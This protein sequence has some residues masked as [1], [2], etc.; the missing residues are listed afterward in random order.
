MNPE[1]LKKLIPYL[2]A[3]PVF[4]LATLSLFY[5][6]LLENK[7]LRQTDIVQFE[8]MKHFSNIY[9]EEN[10]ETA[11]WNIGMFS[12]FPEF[13]MAGVPDGGFQFLE[14]LTAGF[15][16]SE[17][18]AHIFFRCAFCCWVMLLCFRL[19]PYLSIMG[20]LAFAFNTYGIVTLEAGHFTKMWAI[21]YA[22]LVV[23][24]MKLLFD[25]KYLL[26]MAVFLGGLIMELRANHFQITY[27]LIIVCLA[28]GISELVYAIRQNDLKDFAKIAVLLL[29]GAGIGA[30]TQTARLWMTLDYSQYSTRGERELPAAE[31]ERSSDN[32]LDK[33]YAFS[34]SQG[35][36]ETL[37][38]LVP[39]LYGGSSNEVPDK[40]SEF[41]AAFEKLAG[42]QQARNITRKKQGMLPLYHGDQPFTSG[43]VYAGA[44]LVFL[45][46]LGMILLPN[47]H[48]IWM[49]VAVLVTMAV[50]WGQNLAW[51]NYFLF[52]YVPGFNKFRS[53]SMALSLSIMVMTIA[54][55]MGV[56][57]FLEK[58]KEDLSLKA[59]AIAFGATAGLSLLIAIG[60]GI[61]M[62]TSSAQDA[63]V[64]QR[65]FG[66]NDSR[67]VN[68]LLNAFEDDRLNL[69][70]SDGFRSFIFI[71]L[72]AAALFSVR[73]GKISQQLALIALGLLIVTDVWLV[74]RR[75]LYP[76][77]FVSTRKQ[78]NT[79]QKTEADTR[80]LQDS[81]PHYRVLDFQ[82]TYNQ[83][84]SSY[85]HKTIGGYFAAKLGRYQDL[86]D[87]RL[88]PEQQLFIGGIQ[89]GKPD[90][91]SL[92]ALN[93]LNAKYFK[94][95]DGAR[96]VM[97]NPNAL[98]N[99]WFVG[100][101]QEVNSPVE[102]IE[103]LASIDP[104]QTAVIDASKF[105][106]AGKSFATDSTATIDLTYFDNRKVSYKTSNSHN[107]LAIFSEIYYPEWEATIDGEPAE[108]KRVNYVLRALEIPAGKHEIQF[109]FK[110]KSYLVGKPISVYT[111][112]AAMAFLLFSFAFVGYK[113]VKE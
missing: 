79:H 102:E 26:G 8:G 1:K 10:G 17:S 84:S 59:I 55:M 81:D 106:V 86:I 15:L 32:G 40:N 82:N 23:G 96:D 54:G 43:P 2:I 24:G 70:Q 39:Y 48:R 22:C 100:K 18:S 25:K 35:K 110:P 65:M 20:A 38:L 4:Y 93:M 89:E 107:G 34:W 63:S 98:G 104:A 41:I 99:A 111:S 78:R 87:R 6:E 113:E 58:K 76:E 12:G 73:L 42:K 66:T 29:I 11:L 36:A 64:V 88:I 71:L 109:E 94:F 105:S 72:A 90:F 45:F 44:I 5:P 53:P 75:Y 95:G 50:S 21:A 16:D 19:N 80:I 49:G 68:T 51:F 28:Y 57:A 83:A 101:V 112:Y 103:A 46:L 74:D 69:A 47:R 56:S 62:D 30:T 33:S 14:S 67:V 3:I 31:G 61:L 9:Y 27:Y 60:A 91:Q 97:L 92:S 52:D 77:K 37:T 108:I 85:F 13:L 7:T